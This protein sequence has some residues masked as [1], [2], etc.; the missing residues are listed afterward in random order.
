MN[1]TLHSSTGPIVIED[2]CLV[3]QTYDGAMLVIDARDIG[4]SIFRNGFELED[5]R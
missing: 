4:D 1:F 3:S 5:M 2:A